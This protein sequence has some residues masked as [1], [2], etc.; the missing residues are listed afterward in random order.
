MFTVLTALKKHPVKLSAIVSMADDGGSTGVL[1][2]EFGILPP[3]DI[4]RAMVAL[5]SHQQALLARLFSYRF[6]EGGLKGYS[7]GNLILTALE[8]TTGSF[9]EAIRCASEL[10]AVEGNVIPVTF[11]NVRLYAKLEDGRVIRGETNIDIPKH[12]GALKIE[13][14]W[15]KPHAVINPEAK[16]VLGDADLIVIGPGD[17]F[18]SI[19]PNMLVRGLR[20]AL[21]T[22]LAR[23][24]YVCNLMTKFGETHGFCARDFITKIEKYLGKNVLHAVLVNNQKPKAQLL[25][26]Y[27]KEKAFFVEPD[28]SGKT[29]LTVARPLL[30]SGKFIRHD[31]DKLAEAL[32]NFLP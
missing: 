3:G 20:E 13:R 9:P 8:R 24:V 29:I 2:E 32:L 10:L 15:L 18:T 22:S 11:H 27:Q 5:S 23:K 16:R 19:I 12:D 26:L 28:T 21:K 14:V 17:L 25:K 31:L 4:R 6:E 30:R 7:F 1:R